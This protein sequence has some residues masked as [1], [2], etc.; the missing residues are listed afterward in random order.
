[1]ANAVAVN[2]KQ[3][4]IIISRLDKV[5]KDIAELKEKLFEQ[6][7]PYGSDAWWEWSIKK[8]E[9]D[10]KAGRYTTIRNKKELRNFLTIYERRYF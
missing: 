3:V 6:E 5:A 9:E 1:M 8:G 4:N 10:I 7:P 2:A